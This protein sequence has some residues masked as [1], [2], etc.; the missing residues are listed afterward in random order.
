MFYLTAQMNSSMISI[1]A[2]VAVH[3]HKFTVHNSS[4]PCSLACLRDATSAGKAFLVLVNSVYMYKYRYPDSAG[5]TPRDKL[6][7]TGSVVINEHL[8]IGRSRRERY[9]CCP[10]EARCLG[11]KTENGLNFYA[12][13]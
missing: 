3:V 8:Y 4:S 1:V 13:C 10:R 11:Y 7:S 9:C 6:V 2:T 12:L 5:D